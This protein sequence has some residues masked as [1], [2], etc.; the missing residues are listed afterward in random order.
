MRQTS[1]ILL[2]LGLKRTPSSA[3]RRA[4]LGTTM[5]A[6][7]KAKCRPRAK[8]VMS[9]EYSADGRPP[10]GAREDGALGAAYLTQEPR[11]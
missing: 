5:P 9:L 10:C 4:A 11:T 3:V 1:R 2:T 7:D 6:V 8:G